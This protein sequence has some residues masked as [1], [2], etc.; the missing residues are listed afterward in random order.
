MPHGALSRGT[1]APIPRR[2]RRERREGRPHGRRRGRDVWL[3]HGLRVVAR[4]VCK[5]ALRR[6]LRRPPW[7]L[8]SRRRGGDLRRPA[9]GVA[10]IAAHSE[11]AST[12][13]SPRH[14]RPQSS[15]FVDRYRGSMSISNT[16]TWGA[17]LVEHLRDRAIWKGNMALAADS[18]SVLAKRWREVPGTVR[19]W[20][21]RS[22]T[23]WTTPS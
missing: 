2:L 9:E 3:V 6:L 4:N 20:P 8:R 13:L 12:S 22:Q 15:T 21:L 23:S 10:A 16:S 5:G 18:T 1:R 17:L 7:L 19:R 11:T 14:S